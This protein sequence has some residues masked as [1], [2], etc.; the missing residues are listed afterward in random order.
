[1]T[2]I[3]LQ[4]Q[5]KWAACMLDTPNTQ[6]VYLLIISKAQQA[7]AGTFMHAATCTGNIGTRYTTEHGRGLLSLVGRVFFSEVSAC[8]NLALSKVVTSDT[9]GLSDMVGAINK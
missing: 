5:C 6:F 8:F 1:M 3:D 2:Q 7:C 4:V 9:S